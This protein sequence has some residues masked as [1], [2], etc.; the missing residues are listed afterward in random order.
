MATVNK[1]V[2][3][4]IS[5]AVGDV[6]FKEKNGKNYVGVRASSFTLPSDAASIERR[7]K[8][9]LSTQLASVINSNPQLRSLWLKAIPA[10]V[11][12]YNHLIK[13]NYNNLQSN[14][15]SD[16]VSIVP[17]FGFIALKQSVTFNNSSIQVVT[18]AIGDNQEIDTSVETKVQLAAVIF[19]N[20]AI[21][22]SVKPRNFITMLS[23][24]QALVLNND[25][26]FE[27]NLSG[28]TSL[29]ISKY[30]VHK[31]FFSL[32]TLDANDELVNY[33]STFIG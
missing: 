11:N 21:D 12:V 17:G 4:R 13:I 24:S 25:L 23:P 6:V 30:Q 5:G 29:I 7:G 1:T 19:L 31:G 18:E 9:Q 26:T 27:L 20:N 3:G 14:S 16:L 22:E 28:Q 15:A 2:L 10:G 33:S 8:F 32:L